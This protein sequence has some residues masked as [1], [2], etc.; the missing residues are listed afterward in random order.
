MRADS[1]VITKRFLR[2]SIGWIRYKPLLL[3]ITQKDNYET[4]IMKMKENLSNVIPKICNYFGN[5]EF[6]NILYEL[7]FYHTHVENHYKDFEDTKS[8]WAKIMKFLKNQ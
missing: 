4:E 3:F 2:A 8:A 5:D 1:S 7:E 6:K